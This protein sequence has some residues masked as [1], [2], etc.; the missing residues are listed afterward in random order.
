MLD[1][2]LISKCYGFFFFKRKSF[3]LDV[4]GVGLNFLKYSLSILLKGNTDYFLLPEGLLSF[5]VARD[6]SIL[7]S[8][9]KQ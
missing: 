1:E 4:Y 6:G 5:T 2:I 7:P 8:S 3:E 9:V